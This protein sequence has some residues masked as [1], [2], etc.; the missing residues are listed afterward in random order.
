MS[1]INNSYLRERADLAAKDS[2][3]CLRE[4]AHSTILIT[5]GTGL[6]G[7]HLVR[8]VLSANSLFGVSIKLILPVRSQKKLD[9]ILVGC[10][11]S[12]VTPM[13]WQLGDSLMEAPGA[14]YVVHGAA[15][16]SSA[17]FRH[18][19]VETI[20][21]IVAGAE[22]VLEYAR[23]SEVKKCLLLSTMEV[24][25]ETSGPC[26]EAHLGLLDPMIVRNSYPEAKRLSE[27][28]FA[29]YADEYGVPCAVARLA[30]T[31]GE[32]A[33]REDT[34]AFAEFARCAVLGQDITLLTDGLKRNPRLGVR[35]AVSGIM[36]LLARSVSGEAYNVANSSTYCSI[37]EMAQ[38]AL[39]E[40]GCGAARVR[41]GCGDEEEAGIYPKST[42]LI[43]DTAKIEAL[44]WE[45]QDDLRSMFRAMVECWRAGEGENVL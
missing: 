44:G 8:T 33:R 24:Y 36:T 2:E 13:S 3:D 10:D 16:T 23:R 27:C 39:D 28:L 34:R 30:Q 26:D 38:A 41:Y 35:D 42:D 14:D 20:R 21:Q 5:G 1:D 18:Q 12:N 31:F 29:S 43:L 7:S 15:G 40:C 6:I 11:C 32:G 45:P 19:P 25:G 22:E 17:G 4:L 37:R 9:E